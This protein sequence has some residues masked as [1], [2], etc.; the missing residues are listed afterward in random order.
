MITDP[1]VPDSIVGADVAAALQSLGISTDWLEEFHY[2]RGTLTLTYARTT[3]E[4]RPLAA[5]DQLATIQVLV[6]VQRPVSTA[7]LSWGPR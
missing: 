1:V 5:G 6:D 2:H 7:Q 4:N 3:A